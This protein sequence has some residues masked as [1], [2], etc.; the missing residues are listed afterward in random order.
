MAISDMIRAGDKVDISLASQKQSITQEI[1]KSKVLDK[2]RNGNFEIEM[3]VKE[4]KIIL[5]PLDVR[6]E[7]VF[8]SQA[9]VL[10]KSCGQVVER[11]KKDGVYMLEI[12]LK[13]PLAKFQRRGYYRYNCDID[14]TFYLLDEKQ[15]E[16]D[17]TEE[18]YKNIML[19]SSEENMCCG[20]MLDLSGGGMRFH[21]K[22]ELQIGEKILVLLPLENEVMNEKFFILSEVISCEECEASLFSMYE[23]RLNFLIEDNQIREE[24]IRYIF[25]ED[26]RIRRKEN[27]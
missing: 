26:R 21:S 27:G 23:C 3:P 4:G 16:L 6:F 9:G 12:E 14:F 25:E 5:L 20:T 7:F 10:Y 19:G 11:Y 18:I 8:Y 15:Q 1:F 17:S 2:K 24:I 13:A 22:H